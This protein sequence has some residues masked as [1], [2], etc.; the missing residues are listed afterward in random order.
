VLFYQVPQ[1]LIPFESG[2]FNPKY[3]TLTVG[4][5]DLLSILKFASTHQNP[6]DVFQF[7][8]QVL[9][10]YAQN[11]GEILFELQ[12]GLP[13]AKIFVANQYTIPDIQ[14]VLPFTDQIISAFNS[15]VSQVVGQFAG[16]VYVVD[17]YQAFLG[18]N[19]LL[20]GQRNAASAF[21]THLTT[22]G[23]RVM[24]QAFADVIGQNK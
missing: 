14:A 15:V 12:T 3:V 5:N 2:G 10:G 23:H 22:T 6:A 7:A 13:G 17:V 4:G 20:L 18:R 1:A 8:N 24:A 19:G 9:T 21:E 11:L 16:N